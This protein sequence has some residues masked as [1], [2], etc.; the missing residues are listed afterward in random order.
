MCIIDKKTYVYPD[1]RQTTRTLQPHGYGF[2]L[3][4]RTPRSP[5]VETREPRR[6][7]S[8]SEE[9]RR[10]RESQ[11]YEDDVIFLDDVS[12][13]EV[14]HETPTPPPA[15]PVY[16][17]GHHRYVPLTPANGT[18]ISN[19]PP[20]L[21]PAAMN[22][23]GPTP[24]ARA[25]PPPPR[26]PPE[27]SPR[28]RSPTPPRGRGRGRDRSHH[29]APIFTQATRTEYR[30][31]PEP[32]Q[33]RFARLECERYEERE[34]NRA[35]ARSEA[36]ARSAS[37]RRR[38]AATAATEETGNAQREHIHAE[39]RP[40]AR[41]AAEERDQQARRN[42][43]RAR[44]RERALE[45][46][47][48]QMECERVAA[49]MRDRDE[50]LA[51]QRQAERDIYHDD[52][53]RAQERVRYHTSRVERQA[54]DYHRTGGA[55]IEEPKRRGGYRWGRPPQRP[56]ELHQIHRVHRSEDLRSAGER[57]LAEER[58]RDLDARMERMR[59]ANDQYDD[60]RYR[61]TDGYTTVR[62]GRSNT[63]GGRG[64]E[65]RYYSERERDRRRRRL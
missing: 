55:R 33:E 11:Q 40:A 45:R 57:V 65:G 36:R 21:T 19:Y 53:R 24:D 25:P 54:P 37:R 9:Q 64:R 60:S 28:H 47:H 1:S 31:P 30:P 18:T 41:T 22:G 7:R 4:P 48:A 12:E 46:E 15:V 23:S 17:I 43:E 49:D 61:Y 6:R 8:C 42:V 63:I 3:T 56:V 32:D 13:V 58:A 51:R 62:I 39:T 26:P 35:A 27:Q 2:P 34:R 20:P 50:W 29:P 14:I 10:P 16:R 5:M 44:E 59:V 52:F 38:D